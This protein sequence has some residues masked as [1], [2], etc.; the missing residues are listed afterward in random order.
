MDLTGMPTILDLA[1]QKG[2]DVT[3]G[4]IEESILVNP[5]VGLFL[6]LIHI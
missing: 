6:S 1:K 5:E 2:N 3:V 4:L